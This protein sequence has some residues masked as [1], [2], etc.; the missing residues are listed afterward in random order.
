MAVKFDPLLG[1]LRAKDIIPQVDADPSS[2]A[3]QDAWV[4]HTQSGSGGS[5]GGKLKT[6]LGFGSYLVTANTGSTITHTYQLSYQTKEGTTK[7]VSLT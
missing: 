7:R 3:S 6:T 4:L 1:K 5:G 2:P